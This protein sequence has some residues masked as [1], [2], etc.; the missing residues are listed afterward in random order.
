MKTYNERTQSIKNKVRAKRDRRV[1]IWS[2]SAAAC[3]M[4]ILVVVC[5]LPILGKDAPNVNAYKNDE[6]YPII[7]KIN[8]KYQSDKHSIFEQIGNGLEGA[9]GDAS[10]APTSPG[11]SGASPEDNNAG[12]ADED[13]KYE[14]TTNNQVAGVIEGDLL[15]RSTT[16]AFYLNSY[17]DNGKLCYNLNVYRLA[18]NDTQKVNVRTITAKDGAEFIWYGSSPAEMFLSEDATRLTLIAPCL[19]QQNVIYTT[20]ISLDVSDVSKITE[21]N[22]VYVSGSYLSSRKI[23]GKLLVI[24]NF[25]VSKYSYLVNEDNSNVIDYS[26]KETYIPQCGSSLNNDFIPMSNIYVPDNCPNINYTVLAMLDEKSLEVNGS[27]AVF[28]YTQ[29][30]YVSR[31]YIVV[32]RNDRYYYNGQFDYGNEITEDKAE[33][34]KSSKQILV[35][36]MVALKYGDKIEKL[37]EIGVEGGI[38]DRYSMDEKDGVLRVFT[39]TRQK[40]NPFYVEDRNSLNVSLYCINLNTMKFAASKQSFAPV[41]DEVKSARFEGDKAYVCTA[42]G[43]IDPVFYFDLSDL[44]NITYV[45][46][47]EIAGF[48]V[49]LIKFNNDL[50]LGIGQ[51]ESWSTLKVELYRESNDPQAEN[52]VVSVASYERNCRFSYEYKAHFVNTE[53]ERGLIGL[54]IYDYEDDMVTSNPNSSREKYLL[55]YYSEEFQSLHQIYLDVFDSG[56][57][58]VRA[59]YK[60]D[61]VYVFG[62]NDFT[63]IDLN[64]LVI[65]M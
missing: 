5:S 36:E 17:Y 35:C 15:K 3:V 58:E 27:Y 48:S 11:V 40:S 39:T 26:K 30:V 6:Y 19:S 33:A 61:G 7:Q 50:L 10:M 55:L 2:A 20:V 37:G 31:D 22:R 24:T 62:T 18:G 59:F 49:N 43:V 9:I 4:L 23:D 60:D 38:K 42:R 16:H 21:I 28:S 12:F 51:G 65:P 29:D 47:G 45:D 34:L 41:G 57:D 54:H 8:S 32:A 13:N 14:E 44:N 46:T 53:P 25:I 64:Q 63:F 1:V 56:S 52:G